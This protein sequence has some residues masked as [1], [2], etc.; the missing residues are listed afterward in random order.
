VADSDQKI[1]LLYWVG[2]AGSFDA[3]GQA[4]ARS[5]VKILKQLNVDFHVLGCRERCTGDP[6][7]RLGEEGLFREQAE[8]NIE[9]LRRH[10]VR[11]ILTHCPHCFN[12]FRNEYPQLASD[13]TW[14]VV[15]HSDF[16]ADAIAHGK[17]KASLSN[18]C[19]TFHDPCYLGRGNGIVR[20]PRSALQAMV[21]TPL[22]EMPRHGAES[23]CCGAGGGALWVDIPGEDRVEH[24]RA[25]EALATNATTVVTA[26]PFCKLM[27]RTGIE[28]VSGKPARVD[29]LAEFIAKAVGG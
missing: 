26:C 22:V 24:L 8:A 17:L 13:V 19:V 3:D 23:F 10:E 29:D 6:A 11:T 18:E 25:R 4:V 28:T 1:D 5:M 15:H 21:R 9:I 14:R 20:A 16:L 7:R 27:L 12:T 2:C